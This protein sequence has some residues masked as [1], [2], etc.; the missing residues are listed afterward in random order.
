MKKTQ[1]NNDTSIKRTEDVCFEK[2][3]ELSIET[4]DTKGNWICIVQHVITSGRR[5][6][7]GGMVDNGCQ[8]CSCDD[9]ALL[10]IWGFE[11]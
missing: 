11:L 1:T 3:D 7:A 8:T 5:L 10:F 4:D 6:S 9:G 2:K